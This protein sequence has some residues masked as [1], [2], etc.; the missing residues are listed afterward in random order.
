MVLHLGGDMIIPDKEIIAILKYDLNGLE[1]S[2]EFFK[3]SGEEGFI[4]Y[5]CSP[6]KAKSYILTQNKIYV[7]PISTATLQK[8]GKDLAYLSEG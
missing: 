5:I 1:I 4:S 6:E 3:E 2:K 8:R 7:S